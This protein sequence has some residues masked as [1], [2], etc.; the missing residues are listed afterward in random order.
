MTE[1]LV[2]IEYANGKDETY[3]FP[4]ANEAKD[5][6]QCAI[7]VIGSD[8]HISLCALMFID[9]VGPCQG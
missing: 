5:V 7:E 4:C 1:Y 6:Y 8:A 9:E 3:W 2:Q